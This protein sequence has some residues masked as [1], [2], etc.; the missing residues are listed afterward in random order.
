[1]K[2]KQTQLTIDDIAEHREFLLKLPRGEMGNDGWNGWIISYNMSPEAV[3]DML[4]RF[5]MTFSEVIE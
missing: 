2:I 5:A 1:M 4:V 3:D